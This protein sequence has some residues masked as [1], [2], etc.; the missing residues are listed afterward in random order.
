[1][2]NWEYIVPH[3]LKWE[4]GYSA[5]PND[6]AAKNPANNSGILMKTGTYKGLP[7][8]TNKGIIFSTW[9]S[10]CSKFGFDCSGTGFVNMTQAQWLK[11]VE[12]VFWNGALLN[13][14]NSQAIAELFFEIHWG[15]GGGGLS[16]IVKQCQIYL[17]K[18]QVAKLVEDGKIGTNTINAINKFCE[19]KQNEKMLY[20]FLWFKRLEYLKSLN[21]WEDFGNG[22]NNR[23]VALYER[24]KGFFGSHLTVSIGLIVFIGIFAYI[25]FKQYSKSL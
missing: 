18:L 13:K 14:I 3:V 25:G 7:I 8:H 21:S 22:W 15:S 2:S 1:M 23:M 6:S 24:A 4:G 17:N 11:I 19:T 20:D 12:V 5:N 16:W 10:Q 9:K